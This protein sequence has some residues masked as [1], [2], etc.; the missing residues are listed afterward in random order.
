[1]KSYLMARMNGLQAEM[2][3][4]ASLVEDLQVRYD[5]AQDVKKGLMERI[6][7]LE[8]EL[9]RANEKAKERRRRKGRDVMKSEGD[10]V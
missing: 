4:R 5:A 9:A 2:E 3:G 8:E 10:G 6:K 7:R 1:V